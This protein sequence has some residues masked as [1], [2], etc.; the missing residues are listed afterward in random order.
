MLM[1]HKKQPSFKL[2]I[3]KNK[4]LIE[5]DQQTLTGEYVIDSH[6]DCKVC[7]SRGS[8]RACDAAQRDGSCLL[9]ID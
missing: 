2:Q 6:K 5:P 7:K 3:G 9:M 8:Y 1:D 4:K